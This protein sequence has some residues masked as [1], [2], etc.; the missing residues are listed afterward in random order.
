MF[1]LHTSLVGLLNSRK[2][3]KVIKRIF[4]K[5]RANF[6]VFWRLAAKCVL[7]FCNNSMK[8]WLFCVK[9]EFLNYLLSWE[10]VITR[11]NFQKSVFARCSVCTGLVTPQNTEN[12]YGKDFWNRVSKFGS[13]WGPEKF[14]SKLRNFQ[15]KMMIFRICL[16]ISEGICCVYRTS[17]ESEFL[18]KQCS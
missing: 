17:G 11:S 1:L 10:N 13:C 3:K 5:M 4:R 8:K 15:W 16:A 9:F 2:E 14:R 7:N 6:W 18:R 12:S